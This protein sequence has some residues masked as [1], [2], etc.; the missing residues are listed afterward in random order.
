MENTVNARCKSN[1]SRSTKANIT[2]HRDCGGLI[3]RLPCELWDFASIP[4]DELPA[5][6]VFEYARECY[7]LLTNQV[8]T[9]AKTA[10]R[11]FLLQPTTKHPGIKRIPA[12]AREQE[13]ARESLQFIEESGF[14]QEAFLGAF[15][16]TDCGYNELYSDI[17]R[18]G[19]PAAKP[20]QKQPPEVRALWTKKLGDYSGVFVPLKP[21]LV[22]RLER[23]WKDCS[24]RLL[25]IRNDPE[26]L[27]K[28]D[29]VEDCELFGETRA[30]RDEPGH[31]GEEHGETIAA[32]Q[33]D[34]KRYTDAAILEG[35]AAWLKASRPADCPEPKRNGKK[36][37]DLR[38]DLKC[39]S[40]M[41]LLNW[42][43]FNEINLHLPNVWKSK[44]FQ[45]PK[46]QD[47]NKWYDARRHALQ[48]YH[49]TLPFLSR[50]DKPQHWQ[51]KAGLNKLAQSEVPAK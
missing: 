3:N 16:N 50:A 5:A 48:T 35:F 31:S 27:A 19:G 9:W 25:E 1:S 8:Y 38:F 41:R 24:K 20:W 44:Q 26:L 39:L 12:T 11:G 10:A 40:V 33:V 2:G 15:Y 29:D 32:F 37:S 23:L 21:A 6:V 51:T 49:E 28:Y 30:I 14:D 34:F 36:R 43:T 17:L 45:G 46:W 18:D 42:F 4:E 47:A 13:D 22:G 7:V